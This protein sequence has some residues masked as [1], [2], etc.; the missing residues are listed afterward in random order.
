[1]LKAAHSRHK[2]SLSMR[3]ELLLYE[4]QKG[5]ESYKELYNFNLTSIE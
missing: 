5:S 1:M 2:L 4:R 3:G